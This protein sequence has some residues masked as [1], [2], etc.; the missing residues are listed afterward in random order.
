MQPIGMCRHGMMVC[1]ACM[2]QNLALPEQVALLLVDVIGI[3]EDWAAACLS[4]SASRF[5]ALLSH[6]RTHLQDSAP[7]PCALV[8]GPDPTPPAGHDDTTADGCN[9]GEDAD[10]AE[11]NAVCCGLDDCALLALRRR[12]VDW[13]TRAE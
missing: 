12:M 4:M 10:Q 11:R 3:E 8:G 6:S 2:E 5:H 1:L 9:R 7:H 13:L